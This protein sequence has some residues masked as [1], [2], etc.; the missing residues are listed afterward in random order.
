MV[1]G[2]PVRR[3]PGEGDAPRLV[4]DVE[5]AVWPRRRGD[6]AA[7]RG[8]GGGGGS[9]GAPRYKLSIVQ[10]SARLLCRSATSARL[11]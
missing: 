10:L 8:D 3:R 4:L 9:A 6:V 7:R 2:R 5:R 1:H 11:T